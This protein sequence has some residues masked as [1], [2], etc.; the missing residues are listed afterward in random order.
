MPLKDA[1]PLHFREA[2][3]SEWELWFAWRPVKSEQG[4]WIWL[5]QTWRRTVIP[6]AWFVPPAPGDGWS[7]YSDH[8]KSFWEVG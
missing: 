7:E 4:K 1:T 8:K 3:F 2:V 5:R 6:P